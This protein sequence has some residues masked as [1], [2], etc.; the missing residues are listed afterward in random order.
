[1]TSSADQCWAFDIETEGCLPPNS[2]PN[3]KHSSSAPAP[4]NI[5]IPPIT[6]VCLYDGTTEHALNFYKVSDE[7]HAGNLAILLHVLDT[8]KV[9][10]GFNAV[11]FD[12][13]YIRRFFAIDDERHALWVAKTVDPYL[14]IKNELGFTCGLSTLLAMNRLPSKSASGLIAIVW[15]KQGHMD[16]VIEYCMMDTKLTRALCCNAPTLRISDAWLASWH[17][18]EHGRPM[19]SAQRCPPPPTAK[20]VLLQGATTTDDSFV[21]TEALMTS[22]YAELA[23]SMR[24]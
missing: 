3:H 2:K 7:L 16:W 22:G 9:L 15:A 23:C 18:D 12:L 17:M 8:A 1:M 14:F 21:S 19:W 11:N 4:S 20:S 24:C 6:C 10:V 13:E 5:L